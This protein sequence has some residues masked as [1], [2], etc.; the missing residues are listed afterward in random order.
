MPPKL[1]TDNSPKSQNSSSA[2]NNVPKKK[3]QKSE[4]QIL[5]EQKLKKENIKGK[6]KKVKKNKSQNI[7]VVIQ[8]VPLS[9]EDKAV[10]R[11]KDKNKELVKSQF[12][13]QK[14]IKGN[15]SLV[16]Y[17]PETK[18][19]LYGNMTELTKKLKTSAGTI[20]SR[21]D[22]KQAYKDIKG[23]QIYRFN[24]SDEA[25]NFK[26]N[27]LKEVPKIKEVIKDIK[28]KPKSELT[29]KIKDIGTDNSDVYPLGKHH[30][31][32]DI[33]NDGM[34]YGDIEDAI[35]QFTDTAIQKRKLQPTDLVRIMVEDANL[36]NMVSHSFVEVRHFNPKLIMGK[37]NEVV[38]SNTTYGISSETTF[39]VESINMVHNAPAFDF[40]GSGY[41]K[42][43]SGSG[44]NKKEYHLKSEVFNKKSLV[45]IKNK[46]DLCM[47]RAIVTQICRIEDGVDSKEY[48]G[49]R[50]GYGIQTERAKQLH[51]D[52]GV[53]EGPC[54]IKE[55]KLFEKYLTKYQIT[56]I[57]DSNAVIYPDV[58][59]PDYKHKEDTNCIYLFYHDNHYDMIVNTKLAGFFSKDYFCHKCK[60]T[61]KKKDCH[62][63]LFKCVMC[64]QSDCPVLKMEH[65]TFNLFCDKCDRFFCNMECFSNHQ[66]I[67][68]KKDLSICD[69]VWKCQTC[70]KVLSKENQPKDKHICGDFLCSNCKVVCPKN[71]KCYM[72]PKPLKKHS[73]KIILFDFESDIS[74]PTHEVMFSISMY[75]DDPTPIEHHDIEEFCL[76]AFCEKHKNHT[77]IAHN[78]KGYDYQFVLKWLYDNTDYDIDTIYGGQKIMSINIKGLRIRFIDSLCFIPLPLKLFPKTFGQNELKKGYFP[79]WFNTKENRNY[80]G[81]MPPKEEFK[82][83]DFKEKDRKDF[84]KWYN[85]K[86]KDNYVWNQEKEMREYCISDV[87]ILR[88]CLIVFRELY[89]K[90]ADIDPL[91][92]LTIAGVCMAIYKYHHIDKEYP[93]RHKD[94]TEIDSWITGAR[95]IQFINGE[96]IPDDMLEF[97]DEMND[98]Y[99]IDISTMKNSDAKETFNK[100]TNEKIFKEKKI[101]IFSY[102]DSLWFRDGFFGGRTNGIKLLYEFKDDEVGMYS[103]ITSLYPTVQYYDPYPKGHYEKIKYKDISNEHYDKI[104]NKEYDCGAFDIELQPPD[105]LYHPV[106]PQKKAGENG[107][108]KLTFDLERKRGVWMSNEVYKALDM[109]YTI[110][111]I[112]EIRY[113]NE[114][115]TEL[116]KS[117]VDTFLKIKQQASGFPDWVFKDK[118]KLPEEIIEARKQLYIKDY[119]EKQGI[120]LD[121]DLIEVNPGLRFI[122]KLCLNSLWG[123][124][125]QRL[126][127]TK[128]ILVPNIAEFYKIIRNPQYEDFNCMELG[129]KGDKTRKCLI[130]YKVKEEFVENDYNTNIGIACFTTSSAR[131]RLYEALETLGRQVLYFDTDSVVYVYDKNNPEHKK[132]ECGDLLGEWTDECEGNLIIGIFVTTGPKAYS[133]I[134]NDGEAHTKIKG[135]NLNW[136]AGKSI[137][138]DKIVKLVKDK[139]IDDKEYK[140]SVEYNMLK[141]N[142][143]KTISNFKQKKDYG[144]TYSKREVLPPDKYNN[145]DTIP[146]GYNMKYY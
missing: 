142:Q 51:I 66:D 24:N 81:P 99:N 80:I 93:E 84:L 98:K 105:N 67:K 58:R 6:N 26:D 19:F 86:I 43:I 37:V 62:K 124:F 97:N 111:K 112:Y 65:K 94:F 126:N 76:W 109:G 116:F 63:C 136:N 103:D 83:N 14:N 41:Y 146:F 121:Y 17:D 132:M 95:A 25:Y 18:Q 107:D 12:N 78:G 130:N 39:I 133:Y 2:G 16:A 53:P 108:I 68:D 137:N 45:M 71:H 49:I 75:Y 64:C 1:N 33:L 96:E 145:I 34:T 7:Q 74:G 88:K 100:L 47:A 56:I 89:I 50:R 122:A 82:P 139:Y 135:F 72:M 38:E 119:Y 21:I 110:I 40:K 79:H 141:R 125:G 28:T 29:Y 27:L 69:K 35:Q 8:D 127:M 134:T 85:A 104:K 9:N 10:S 22:G 70:K 118:D 31:K 60:K 90:I 36:K 59:S 91:Q 54:G 143:D 92:Y 42:N 4:K 44:G 61:Y 144:I 106:L 32:I 115:T 3:Y 73:E 131:L 138:H 140:L 113:W 55:V 77:L 101:G 129:K 114:T 15:K 46:D 48:N 5:K 52:A 23:F 30:Y 128:S 117:Y 120:Q 57:D 11:H 123:K 87:D 102:N 20:K 13:K